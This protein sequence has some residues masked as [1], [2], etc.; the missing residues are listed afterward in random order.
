[1]HRHPHPDSAEATADIPLFI[2]SEAPL[3]SSP[4]FILFLHD[5]QKYS[6]WRVRTKTLERLGQR[7]QHRNIPLMTFQIEIVE[8]L[9]ILSMAANQT[10]ELTDD[11]AGHEDSPWQQ[12][13]SRCKSNNKQ[14]KIADKKDRR[15]LQAAQALCRNLSTATVASS[16]L[17][18]FPVY[19]RLLHVEGLLEAARPVLHP[20]SRSKVDLCV[21]PRKTNEGCFACCS[22]RSAAVRTPLLLFE[23]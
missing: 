9:A 4:L 21:F 7:Y 3:I 16:S 23:P 17:V 22:L 20:G 14:D 6:I 18:V 13:H 5:L 1:M 8:N 2:W 10:P 12:Q 19:F 11:R 15:Q